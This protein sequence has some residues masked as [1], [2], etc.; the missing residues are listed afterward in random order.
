[1]M[2]RSK[3]EVD[4]SRRYGEPLSCVIIDIDHFK[5]IND[6]HGHQF[7]DFVLKKLALLLRENTRSTDTCGRYGGEEFIILARLPLSEVVEYLFRLHSLIAEHI[8]ISG[9][10]KAKITV[11]MGISEYENS[12]SS[13]HDLVKRADQ[14]LYKAKNSG[15]NVVRIWSSEERTELENHLENGEINRLKKQFS[16]LYTAAKSRYVQSTNALLKAIDAKDRYTLNHSVNVAAYAAML[17]TAAGLNEQAGET[18][19]YA[20][21]LHDVGK[22]GISKRILTKRSPLTNSEYERLK[23]H[24]QIGANIIKDIGILAKEIP[25]ILHHHERY[26]GTG[27]P[28]G[29]RANEIPLGAK[30]LSIADAFDAMTTSRD[31]RD[32]FSKKEAIQVLIAEKGRQF[33]PNLVDLFL[34]SL[35]QYSGKEVTGL[36]TAV[37]LAYP[38][39]QHHGEANDSPLLKLRLH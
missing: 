19:K 38:P 36:S 29:L 9:E 4:R 24:P 35:E 21:L 6:C 18:V 27:Y 10:K 20:A 17:A 15:R 16:D 31:F 8:F 7:G 33:D 22:I 26:D 13:W 1:M 30:I 14:A 23:R 28:H 5:E 32:K 34:T 3:N 2:E 25:I 12:L 37:L 11:S 39:F